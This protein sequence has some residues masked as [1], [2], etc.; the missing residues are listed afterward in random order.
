MTDF[1]DELDRLLAERGISL[2]EAARSSGYS[3]G[4]LS[5][6]A[7][8]RKPLTPSLA[9]ML[10]RALSTGGTF[11]AYAL[12]PGTDQ[13][14]ALEADPAIAALRTRWPGVRI[15]MQ[16][17]NAADWHLELPAG[18]Q[19][20]GRG[21]LA[22]RVQPLIMA[23]ESVAFLPVQS[24]HLG[25]RHGV[26][27]GFDEADSS[28]PLRLRGLDAHTAHRERAQASSGEPV[29]SVPQVYELDDLSGGII[30]ALAST[31]DALLA[32]DYALDE[33]SRELR[34]Y[35]SLTESAVSNRAAAGMTAAA[36][37]WLGSSFCARHI[38]RNLAE[39]ASV[40]TFWTREQTGEEASAWLLF[41]HKHEYL[42]WISSV[43]G[44]DPDQ[45]LTRS[46]CIPE[47]VA[48]VMPQW[49]RILLLLAVALMESLDIKVTICADAGYADTDGFALLPD[50]A[51]IATW[52]RAE[53]I[54]YAGATSRAADLR[55]FGEIT[56][57]VNAHSVTESATPIARLHA[58]AD[59]LNLDWTW[60][61]RRCAE[62]GSVGCAQLIQPHSRLLSTA[63]LDAALRFA[64][65]AG[66]TSTAGTR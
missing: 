9:N 1:S 65:N 10:D 50:R 8:G 56:S 42:Q 32:D 60:L 34:A 59:Y 25:I 61:S 6:V 35:E 16:P 2:R 64:G 57:H 52:V 40:P 33:R 27:L 47:L 17:D 26:L 62:L 15:S 3:P 21:Q 20:D 11:T 55:D 51:V 18:R 19:L 13:H 63:G 53:G 37:M 44:G 54:W 58:L 5:N 4:Y 31:D 48:T 7:S 46:F 43:F 39:P 22:A 41:R 28:K 49:E 38:L 29:V 30:W 14:S 66:A 45:P 23:D 12:R 36:R 24:T